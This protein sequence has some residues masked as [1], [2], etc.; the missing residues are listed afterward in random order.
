ME[1][2]LSGALGFG[3]HPHHH[4][5]FFGELDGVA[6]QV[7]Q[8]LA[9]AQFVPPQPLWHLGLH[10]VYQLQPLLMG[11]HR[12]DLNH[13][14]YREAQGEILGRQG[15]LAGFDL[16]EVEHLV[17]KVQQAVGREFD[18]GQLFALGQ[19][20]GGVEQEFGQTDNGVHRRADLVAH[21]GE[22][23]ALGAAGRLGGGPGLLQL[24]LDQLAGGDVAR[25]SIDQALC[26]GGGGG[27][28]QPAV[29]AVPAA[30]AVFEGDGHRVDAQAL[31]LVQG[32]LQVIGM[33]EVDEG[34][35]HKFFGAEAQGLFPGGIQGFEI[36]VRARD[37]QQVL[38]EGEEAVALQVG[39]ALAGVLHQG[40]QIE[41]HRLQVIPGGV[42]ILAAGAQDAGL[43]GHLL[44][45]SEQLV[46][47]EPQQHRA[48][49]RGRRHT[50]A[51]DPDD[52]PALG[53]ALC[54]AIVDVAFVGGQET[55]AGVV[56]LLVAHL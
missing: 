8:H 2:D 15:K 43:V 37:A 4:L 22:K 55:L 35:G 53:G 19:F 27:P 26:G 47:K 17:D 38:R 33:D 50:E 49:D 54:H 41:T 51:H 10:G 9:Q 42:G 23:L 5:A 16:G 45:R 39:A 48:E 40:A 46:I 32:D 36:A 44:K 29:L 20:E 52:P 7:Y 1:D 6:H 34:P 21:V 24:G 30:I 28:G 12:Q 56:D 11:A 18:H 3:L 14:V 31:R 25:R 13:L